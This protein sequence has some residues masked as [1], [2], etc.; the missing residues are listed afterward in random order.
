M[1]SIK[2][3]FLRQCVSWLG[4]PASPFILVMLLSERCCRRLMTSPSEPAPSVRLPL[5][6]RNVD[7]VCTQGRINSSHSALYVSALSPVVSSKITV[8]SPRLK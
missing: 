4:E 5:N 2:V 7:C 3:S 1:S 8:I 6:D